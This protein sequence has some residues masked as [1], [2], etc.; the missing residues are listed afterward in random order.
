MGF[1]KTVEIFIN[2]WLILKE[3][4][5]SFRKLVMKNHRVEFYSSYLRLNK[6]ISPTSQFPSHV[7]W[8]PW[9]VLYFNSR[10]LYLSKVLLTFWTLLGLIRALPRIAGVPTFQCARIFWGHA[11][12]AEKGPAMAPAYVKAWQAQLDSILH[13][14]GPIST[15][16]W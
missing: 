11:A 16:F 7:M 9:R 8:R 10:C 1:G 2:I 5:K 13:S 4:C 3:S 14:L 15:W 6:C 12:T